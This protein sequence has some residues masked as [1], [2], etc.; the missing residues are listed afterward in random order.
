MR[1]PVRNLL[2]IASASMLTF[3]GLV[4]AGPAIAADFGGNLSCPSSTAV[5]ARGTKGLPYY[6]KMGVPGRSYE[7]TS[8]QLLVVTLRG[9]SSAGSW[10]VKG[11]GATAGNG[12][13]G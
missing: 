7:D 13:C 4:T 5:S 8:A 2:V 12:F 3:G 6:F 1:K 10:Y 11:T 9:S